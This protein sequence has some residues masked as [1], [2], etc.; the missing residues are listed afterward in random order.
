MSVQTMSAVAKHRCGAR[1]A[2]FGLRRSAFLMTATPV[3]VALMFAFTPHVAHAAILGFLGNFDVINDTGSTCY[4]FEIDLEGVHSTEVTDVFGGPGRGF[5]TGRGYD[6]AT[7]VERYGSPSVVE[8]NNGATYGTKVT[9]SAIYDGMSW[10]FNTPSTSPGNFVTPGDNCWTGGGVGYGPGTPCD[11]FG[12][13]TSVTPTKTTYSWLHESTPGN[14]SNANGQVTLPAPAWQVI[15]APPPPPPGQP[16]APPQVVAQIEAPE[17]P[18]AAEF[19][20][21]LWV[22]VFTTELED[23]VELEQLVGGDPHVE[24]AQTE[25]EWQL[26]QKDI[27]NPNSGMLESGLGVPVGP[28]AASIL[29]R[30]E[31]YEFSGRYDEETHE[32]LFDLGFGDSNPGPNDVGNYLG[33]QNAAVN[34]NVVPEPASVALVLAA[35]GMI[36]VARGSRRQVA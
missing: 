18:P 35:L 1:P 10:D 23:E 7:S 26:L 13:G 27:N 22:K 15:P 5:P 9:Y 17:P 12:V 20:E 36:G 28:N 31:F 29:R 30:Y 24:Q 8:Y 19:G 3:V 2:A 32:A 21:A 25:I 6:P 11:H 34:L 4:G 14:L 33:S 16:Q